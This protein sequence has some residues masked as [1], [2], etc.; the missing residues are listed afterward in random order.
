MMQT[1]MVH[2]HIA[3]V[4][5][6]L[7]G[8][9]MALRLRQEGC[10]VTLFDQGVDTSA[11]SSC[12]YQGAGMLAP[13][14]EM[15]LAEP[16]IFRLGQASL[17]QWPSVLAQLSRPVFFQQA[18][19]L[20]VAHNR[21]TADL[22]RLQ[23]TLISRCPQ[24]DDIQSVTPTQIAS[25]E[26]DLTHRFQRGLYISTEGQLDNRQ[27]LQALAT[28]LM[29]DASV[30]WHCGVVVTHVAPGRVE[31]GSQ[32]WSFDTVVDC[33]GLGAKSQWSALRGVRGEIIRVHAPDVTLNRLIR[34]THP[35]YPLYVAPRQNNTYVIG[36]T[37]IES[38]DMTPIT[39]QSALELLSAAYALH[40]G[41][42]EASLL[43]M[44]VHCRPAF[45]D[46]L[47]RLRVE[48]GLIRIN[49][50]YRHGFLITPR[51]VD[52]AWMCLNNTALDH[53]DAMVIDEDTPCGTAGQR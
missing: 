42:A 3:V 46:N 11:L 15:E 17:A 39:L 5:A 44:G 7:A 35:R 10:S 8:R 23:H 14:S 33:R 30:T 34:L 19:T 20:V 36:A 28:T 38:D 21:D 16:L 37:S 45:P 2:P 50:L 31:D 32:R 26:P 52:L 53:A 1:H 51:L 9:L 25:L 27:L 49:G 6:G 47:P 13:Y 24:P 29:E 4:G 22:D 48:P 41:F 40:P 12:T 18:G 43:E